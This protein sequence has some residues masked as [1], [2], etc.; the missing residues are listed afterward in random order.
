[1]RKVL[2]SSAEVAHIWAAQ[3][4]EH[5]R[6]GNMFFDGA[7][8]YSYGTHFEIARHVDG[9]VL[10][11]TRG[12]SNSTS[13][14][15]TYP[16]RAVS[17]KTVF[18]VPSFTDHRANVKHYLTSAEAS[19]A[20]A[21]RAVLY[22]GMHTR[23]MAADIAAAVAYV[24]KF[25]KHVPKTLRAAVQKLARKNKAGRMFTPAEQAKLAGAE[26]RRAV[27]DEKTAALCAQEHAEYVARNAERIEEMRAQLIQWAAGEP[28]VAAPQDYSLRN[29]LPTLLRVKDKRI[30]TSQGAQITLRRAVEL[31]TALTTGG[32][33]VGMDLDGFK[34]DAWDGAVLTVGCHKIPA[35]EVAR[36]GAVLGL[37][38]T[39][40]APAAAAAGG[41]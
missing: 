24:K 13:K 1:M 3:S 5:G 9:V 17:H 39:L 28:G 37:D 33:V 4:Q 14:H 2:K 34:V 35:A 26:Q 31:W 41:M 29:E 16:A 22:G 40:T 36:L 32:A 11:T 15:K 10:F 30:E 23:D 27:R 25:R 6:A 19:R 12:Y 18:T 20:S 8:I 38:G 7:S 21:L